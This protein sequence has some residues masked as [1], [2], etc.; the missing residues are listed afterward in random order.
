MPHTVCVTYRMW[1]TVQ[2][3]KYDSE[4][5]TDMFVMIISYDLKRKKAKRELALALS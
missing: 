4:T 3:W 2:I 1:H 5:L